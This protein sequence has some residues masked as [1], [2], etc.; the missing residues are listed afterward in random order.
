MRTI[1]WSAILRVVYHDIWLGRVP[2]SLLVAGLSTS[3][4]L[5]Y[6]M[7]RKY[8]VRMPWIWLTVSDQTSSPHSRSATHSLP[9]RISCIPE[10]GNSC[11][12]HREHVCFY[13]KYRWSINRIGWMLCQ[14][15]IP[16]PPSTCNKISSK[17][18][19][20]YMQKQYIPLIGHCYSVQEGIWIPQSLQQLMKMI[21]SLLW[22]R[23][24]CP[25]Q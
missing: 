9:P 5:G 19:F 12:P 1:P 20:L 6:E 2:L 21:I 17:V 18:D 4:R 11:L 15:R 24:I 13:R 16:L 22:N 25:L 14:L 7:C 10:T 8:L 3:L 23:V